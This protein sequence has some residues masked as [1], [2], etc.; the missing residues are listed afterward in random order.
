MAEKE[1]QRILTEILY[2]VVNGTE[3]APDIAQ[4]L[5]EET[6]IS[7]CRLAKKHDVLHVVSRF[8]FANK[9]TL[10]D[11]VRSRLEHEEFV[12]VYR[13]G[14]MK[15]AFGEICD[16][17]DGADIAY[18]PLKGSVLRPYYPYESMRTSCDIDILIK[19][20][21]IDKA[22]FCFEKL[23]YKT[24]GRNYHDVSLYSPSKIHLELHFNVFEN[25]D[26]LDSVLKDAWKHTVPVSGARHKFSDEFFAFH[27]FSHMAYH[28]VSGGCGIRSLLDV[29]VMK[30][31]MGL[32]A[33]SAKALLTKA[34]I[35]KF[36]EE[37]TNIADLSF[38]DNGTDAF[39][40]S[41]LKYIYSGGVYGN[42]ENSITVKKTK[43]GNIIRYTLKR[44]FLPYRTMVT[45]FPI[46]KKAP[47]LLPF[48]WVIRWIKAI[49][50]K[51][52]GRI[53]S[54]VSYASSISE[55]KLKETK[56]LLDRLQL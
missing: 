22:V 54:E 20:T 12:S 51:K 44:L 27:I 41:V 42:A 24:E 48:C 10:S 15:H 19:E 43:S 47:F 11:A 33:E 38:T 56:A 9:L 7:V 25:I 29:W 18:V 34:G 37:M 32:T 46:L 2:S 3:E 5:T 14:Q 31:K 55:E 30:H 40:D 21:D 50:N 28:F 6:L 52:S 4:R 35:Y 36:A 1:I 23:G 26:N 13:L 39:S 45:A 17:L 49:F 16:T 53:S 8:V